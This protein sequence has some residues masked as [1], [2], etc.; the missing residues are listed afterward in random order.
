[1]FIRALHNAI[2]YKAV[3]YQPGQVFEIDGKMGNKMCGTEPPMA[4]VAEMQD[5]LAYEE[6]LKKRGEDVPAFVAKYLE[7][8]R[9]KP[10]PKKGKKAKADEAPDVDEDEDPSPDAQEDND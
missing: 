1:M 5:F 7:E 9:P 3:R 6:A 2:R 10:E 4:R 8:N